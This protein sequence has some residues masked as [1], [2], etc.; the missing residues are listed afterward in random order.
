MIMRIEQ[1]IVYV[2]ATAGHG[3]TTQAIADTINEEGLYIL[4]NGQLVSDKLV[5]ATIRRYADIFA[6]EGGLIYL[7]M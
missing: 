2:L 3:M 6:R 4:N 5:Y 7:I 1:A